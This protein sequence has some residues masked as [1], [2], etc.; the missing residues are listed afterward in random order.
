MTGAPPPAQTDLALGEVASLAGKAAR[1]S[2]H[3]WGLAEDAA[4]AVRSLARFGL[5]GPEALLAALGCDPAEDPILI[6]VA[7]SDRAASLC[8]DGPRSLPECLSPLLLVPYVLR[9]AKD[10]RRAFSVTCGAA[11]FTCLAD[12]R[13][14]QDGPAAPARGACVIAQALGELPEGLAP[15]SRANVS[16]AVIAGLNAFAAKT[17]APATEASRTRGAGAGET[18]QD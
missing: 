18:D 6:G 13:I 7:L 1:G 3:S 5:P 10:Q 2:G 14:A 12:G 9:A 17:Y 4:D 11:E 15:H 8:Q 16:D